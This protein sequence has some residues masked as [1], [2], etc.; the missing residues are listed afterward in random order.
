MRIEEAKAGKVVSLTGAET[1]Y[2]LRVGSVGIVAWGGARGNATVHFGALAL[3][4][5]VER[6]TLSSVDPVGLRESIMEGMAAKA[7]VSLGADPEI[8][9]KDQEGQVIPAWEWLPEKKPTASPQ[10]FWDGFQAEFTVSPYFCIA[11]A[12]DEVQSQ[13]RH[14]HSLLRKRD[15]SLS[16]ACVVDIPYQTLRAVSTEQASLGCAPSLNIYP[17]ESPLV[18]EDT[19]A[20]LMR[21]AG[22]H[23]HF[24]LR[25]LTEED[26]VPIVY[27][28]DELCG[29]GMTAALDGME[30][31][32]RRRYYGRAGEHRLPEHGLEYRVP[33]SVALQHPVLTQLLYHLARTAVRLGALRLRLWEEGRVE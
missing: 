13:L 24:G 14:L 27:A 11:Y 4:I 9:A 17:D 2:D 6:L 21:F 29:I 28:L 16:P 10:C 25:G 5:P 31:G 30:D 23:V 32:R 20:L 3:P 12:V 15:A 8:F 22:Y 33:S 26:A 19:R 7:N 18:V 1:G